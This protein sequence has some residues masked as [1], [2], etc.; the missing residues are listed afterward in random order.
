MKKSNLKN[1][2][3]GIA[4]LFYNSQSDTLHSEF[5]TLVLSAGGTI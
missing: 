4:P 3:K 1:Q 2:N 5:Y